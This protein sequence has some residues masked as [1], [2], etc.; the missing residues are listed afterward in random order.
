MHLGR[1][2][3]VAGLPDLLHLLP[4]APLRALG[5]YVQPRHLYQVQ[6]A[7]ARG[8]DLALPEAG[9]CIDI[10]W[11]RY[12]SDAHQR[13]LCLVMCNPRIR[14]RVGKRGRVTLLLKDPIRPLEKA[15]IRGI[16]LSLHITKLER[17]AF[18]TEASRVY[19][20]ALGYA[21]RSVSETP[22]LG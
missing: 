7:K 3:A 18:Y 19:E 14:P 1:P 15:N 4:K 10:T 9:V 2:N 13:T 16:T 21:Q 8:P 20:R 6:V 11:H 5:E 22:Q 17:V 12:M